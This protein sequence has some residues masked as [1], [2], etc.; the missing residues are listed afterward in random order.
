MAARSAERGNYCTLKKG[1]KRREKLAPVQ[2]L[3]P[4]KE[5]TAENNLGPCTN[6]GRGG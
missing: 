3:I 5:I 4:N 1:K 6:G 2:S